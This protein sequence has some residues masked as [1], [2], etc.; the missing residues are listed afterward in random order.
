MFAIEGHVP[1]LAVQNDLCS[2]S[3]GLPEEHVEQWTSVPAPG[4]HG[5]EEVDPRPL[6][7]RLGKPC[8]Q[9]YLASI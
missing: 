2:S 3:I 1:L 5:S 7:P 4:G 8:A 6:A 9:H